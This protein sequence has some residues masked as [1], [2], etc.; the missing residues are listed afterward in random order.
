MSVAEVQQRIALIQ[1]TTRALAPAQPKVLGASTFAKELGGVMRAQTANSFEG[2]GNIGADA[3]ELASEFMGTPYVWGGED[4]SG[5]DCSGLVQYVYGKLGVQ[6]PRVSRDQAKAG[7]PV[8]I[9]DLQKGDLVFYGSPVVDHVGIYAGDGKMVVAPKRGDV[10][11]LQNVDFDRVV[12]ARRVTGQASGPESYRA[13]ST[14]A[15]DL[16]ALPPAA[17]PY[18]AMIERAAAKAGIDPKLLAALAWSESNFRPDAVS[19]AGALGMTQ[20]MPA[21]A[22]G[23]GVDPLDPE[24]NLE[25]G[26]RYLKVQ[27]DRFGRVDHALAAY[28]AGPTAVRKAGG[29]PPYAETQG[30]VSK[31]LSRVEALS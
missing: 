15:L 14:G 27:L 5:F 30:F 2:S 8:A 10:V 20:L 19:S 31:V 6:V 22:R 24:Q 3:V 29:I 16:Q 4:P 25:G 17:R 12:A 9:Q 13:A 21:T 7:V 1:A 26:A 23:M 28:N 18:A 11:K